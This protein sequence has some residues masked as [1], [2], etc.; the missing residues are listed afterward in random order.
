M[1]KPSEVWPKGIPEVGDKAKRTRTVLARDIELFTEMSG[2]RNP[3]HYDEELAQ[4]VVRDHR[5][6]FAIAESV[7]Y[8][9]DVHYRQQVRA[10]GLSY[11]DGGYWGVFS[12]LTLHQKQ[13]YSSQK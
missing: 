13:V 6:L 7:I 3:L 12:T 9:R 8:L 4:E 10:R 1:G 11:Q 5:P 2:D